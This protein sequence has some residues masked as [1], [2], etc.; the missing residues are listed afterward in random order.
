MS[1]ST[2]RS[3]WEAVFCRRFMPPAC[4]IRISAWASF[5]QTM[6]KVAVDITA[7]K[8]R[9]RDFAFNVDPAGEQGRERDCATRLDHELQFPKRERD[10]AR[11]FLIARANALAYQRAIDRKG[12]LAGRACHQG[13][14]NGSGR[15]RVAFAL[16]A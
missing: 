12:E 10:R 11:D 14:A 8:H 16:P 15:R 6:E 1:V 13:I 3:R 2:M 7:G 9:T 4:S 5:G